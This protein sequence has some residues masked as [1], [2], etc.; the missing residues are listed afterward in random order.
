MNEFLLQLFIFLLAAAISVPIAKKLGLDSVLGYLVAGVIIGPFGLRLIADVE[1]VMNFTEF[2]IVMMLFIVGLELKPS[3]LIKMKGSIF[4]TGS[5]QV[6][7][8]AIIF[9]SLA[10]IFFSWQESIA[11]GLAL[12][13]SSTA[14]VVQSLKEK[15]LMQTSSGR[16][17]FS[18]LL[19]QDLAVIPI[20]ALFP[21]LATYS[22]NL[23]Y[24]HDPIL[25][26]ISTL[27]AY[28]ET[29]IIILSILFIYVLSKYISKPVFRIIAKTNVR[30]IFI[31]VTLVI[32]V[33]ISLLM[34]IVG[35]SPVLGV[36]IAG[37]VLANS[38]YRH[39]LE[40]NV[41][42]FKGILLGI[43]F[44]SIGASMNLDLIIKNAL[45]ILCIA[46][47][48]I[49]LKYIILYFIATI[50][51]MKNN[52][53]KF[54]SI[55]LA[56]GGEFAFVLFT[57]ANI[58]GVLL[59]ETT[60][61]VVASVVLTMFISPILFNIFEK[62]VCD[63]QITND[64]SDNDEVFQASNKKVILAGFGQLGIDIGRFLISTGIKPTILDHDAD[65][66]ELLKKLGFEVYYGD[67]T[68]LDLLEAAGISEAKLV[69]ISISNI[70][71][72]EKIVEVIKKH[73]PKVKIITAAEDYYATHR[74]IDLNVDKVRITSLGSALMLG[75][76]ALKTLGIDPYDAYRLMR[77]FRKHN[78]DMIKDLHE[79]RDELKE[80]VS[81]YKKQLIELEKLM[82]LDIEHDKKELDIAWSTTDPQL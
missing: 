35:L 30:E 11:I 23:V 53:K 57:F 6:I 58:N 73:Y 76:D 29:I 22:P 42:P 2:G 36:F 16:S 52:D 68:R 82:K 56:Q 65:N 5:V 26:D 21:L 67:V 44:I 43:F 3:L 71:V 61:L 50:F 70:D 4:G 34:T 18:V 47:L 25:F 78:D 48:I 45:I 33:G 59:S 81:T 9:G 80:Y 14:I 12:A 55:S 63:K 8:T 32:V 7:L 15:G 62:Y 37:V 64:F 17:V 40:S 13:L 1:S 69:I 49:I 20:M 51:S 74:L 66:I 72:S 39:E 77:I 38:E 24:L 27:P 75:Q 79:N 19:F 10:L 54:F 60:D 41:E 28:L 31:A 46:A